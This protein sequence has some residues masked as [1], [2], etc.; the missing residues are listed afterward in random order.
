MTYAPDWLTRPFVMSFV[1]TALGVDAGLYKH[2]AVLVNAN[3]ERFTDELG[4]AGEKLADQPGGQ[5]YVLLDGAIAERFSAW[6]HFISTAPS[7]AYAYIGDYRRNRR[8]ICHEGLSVAQLAGRIGVPA[9]KLEDTIA[10]S[11][12]AQVA[13]GRP[14]LTRAPWTALGPI[15]AY[16]VLTDG[17][18]AVTERLEVTGRDGQPIP[19]LYAAGS[20]GQGGVLLMG[21][22]HH[23]GWAFVSGRIAGRNAALDGSKA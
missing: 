8:D 7:V 2:G 18:L 4:A 16:T 10:R 15:K 13:A 1:T 20:T 3:G 12:A 14:V 6:P 23:L 5:A 17:G 11:N 19:G 22:G 9:G 21:H